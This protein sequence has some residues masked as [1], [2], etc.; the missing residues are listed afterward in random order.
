MQRTD[1]VPANADLDISFLARGDMGAKVQ[2]FAEWLRTREL[3]YTS[4]CNCA[5]LQSAQTTAV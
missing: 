3:R 5:R 1:Q 4:I 2:S